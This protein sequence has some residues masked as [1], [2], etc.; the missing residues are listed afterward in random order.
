MSDPY[1]S[2]E[3]VE[4][5]HGDA[6]ELLPTIEADVVITDPPYGIAATS[7]RRQ[8]GAVQYRPI[9]GD[10][11]T[12]AARALFEW[13]PAEM[14]AA[15]FGANCFPEL[16]PHPGRWVCWDKRL[17]RA[18]DRMLGSA[19]ELA[20]L[21]TSTGYDQ[22]IRCLHGGVVNANGHGLKRV[23]PTEKPVPMLRELIGVVGG[24]GVICDPFAGSGTTLRAAKDLGRRAVGIELD[25]QYCEVAA[26][27]MGQGVLEFGDAS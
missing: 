21:N 22:M 15:V 23:H 9:A 1:Y 3:L 26:Q 13:L 5:Y 25:E 20:W 19:F 12:A 27:R 2:D 11:D 8:P 24:S 18:A 17:T 6:L 16:L 14:P 4:I 10:A 7:Y